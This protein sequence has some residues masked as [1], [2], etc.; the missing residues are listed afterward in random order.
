VGSDTSNC[1]GCDKP[2]GAP[3]NA[4]PRCNGGSCGFQCNASLIPCAGA[5]VDAKNDIQNCGQ[6]GK[7]CAPPPSGGSASCVNSMCGVQCNASLTACGGKC[8]NLSNDKDN[9]GSCGNQCKGL[10]LGCTAGLCL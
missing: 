8:V 1:G 10:L 4:M 5:C 7:V 9:C 6:C 2:C 3:V